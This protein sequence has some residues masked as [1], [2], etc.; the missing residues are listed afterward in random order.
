M[1]FEAA[2]ESI[3]PFT[4]VVNAATSLSRWTTGSTASGSFLWTVGDLRMARS[5]NSI[6]HS[7]I[8]APVTWF[9]VSLYTGIA[10]AQSNS[11]PVVTNITVSQRTDGSQMVDIRYDLADADGDACDI[12]V[13]ATSDGGASWTVPIN[14]VTGAVGPAVTPGTGKQIVWNSLADVPAAGGSPFN[15]RVCADDGQGPQPPPGKVLIIGGDFLMGDESGVGDPDE[16]PRHLV[17]VASFYMD[18]YEVTNQQYAAGLNWALQHGRIYIGI[19]YVVY[20][21][22]NNW[23]YC[24]TTQ[25]SSF[26]RITWSGSAFGVVPG[27]EDHP[28]VRFSWFGAAA[29]SNWLGEIEGRT[30]SYSFN[31]SNPNWNCD[32][33]S[34]GYRLPTEAEW[35][36]AA[37]GGILYAKY[38]WGD[39]INGPDAN[40]WTSGDPYET[41]LYPWTTPVGF[42]D[43]V[44]HFKADFAWPG[45][46]LT[47]QTSNKINGYG[48][49]DMAGNVAEWVNDWYDPGTYSVNTYP[50]RVVGPVNGIWRVLR[51]GSWGYF[52]GLGDLRC[53]SRIYFTPDYR[54]DNFGFRLVLN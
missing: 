30:T 44:L 5:G 46:Q 7:G 2:S 4:C 33:L 17:H 48:L 43:G 11:P 22:V 21:S 8:V 52:G 20:G 40:Y 32:F 18:C 38:P 54:G 15:V 39:S 12:F 24:D 26:S 3:T 14:A 25:S 10:V 16:M 34:G 45:S 42:Y 51:G 36:Y 35:E 27:Q 23:V 1:L 41:G 9:L 13:E 19:D 49:Y 28:V 37:R 47:Y 53:A 50:N 6:E 29:Y 31:G